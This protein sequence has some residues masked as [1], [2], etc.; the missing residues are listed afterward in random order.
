SCA[1]ERLGA[2]ILREVEPGE[3]IT[4]D[5]Q[6]MHAE[7]LV[8]IPRQSLCVFEYIYFSDATSQLDGRYVYNVREALGRELALEHPIDADMVVPVPDSS[9]PAALGYSQASSIP[10]G[11]GI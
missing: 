2:T 7:R 5:D 9:I 10:Y 3:L 11:Q 6:G 4:I 1:F 8:Q